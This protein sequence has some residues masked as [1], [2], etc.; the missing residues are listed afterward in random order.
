MLSGKLNL[1]DTIDDYHVAKSP[2]KGNTN[3]GIPSKWG[4]VDQEDGKSAG[5]PNEVDWSQEA[6][7]GA[8]AVYVVL[9]LIS[10]F[11]MYQSVF[12]NYDFPKLENPPHC[13]V[14]PNRNEC[15]ELLYPYQPAN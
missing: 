9:V 14:V 1:S 7:I 5:E 13:M 15:T 8:N 11:L 4:I 2:E 10:T 3:Q 12:N 6:F